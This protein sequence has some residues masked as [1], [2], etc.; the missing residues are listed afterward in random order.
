MGISQFPGRASDENFKIGRGTWGGGALYP[1]S[2]LG[3][4]LLEVKRTLFGNM[5]PWSWPSL[6]ICPDSLGCGSV[7]SGLGS[8]DSECQVFLFLFF[9]AVPVY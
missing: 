2:H 9:L 3:R 5:E 8:G 1:A 4:R 6:Q 7:S